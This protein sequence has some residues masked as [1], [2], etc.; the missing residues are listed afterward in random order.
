MNS[1]PGIASVAG[2]V[3]NGT[4]PLGAT[5]FSSIFQIGWAFA[6]GIMFAIITCAPTSGGHFNPAITICF[7]IWQG[8]PWKKVPYYIFSQVFGSF[9]AGLLCVGMYWEQISAYS[10]ELTAQGEPLVSAT[11]PAFILCT[12]PLPT[13]NNQGYLFLIEFFVD[14][15]IVSCS[16]ILFTQTPLLATLCLISHTHTLFPYRAS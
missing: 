10:A 12:F 3:L 9:V 5:A 16:S 8:F 11:G 1:F 6:L 2:F 7:A 13:Q 14:S 4:S 15:F